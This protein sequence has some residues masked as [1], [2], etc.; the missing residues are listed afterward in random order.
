MPFRSPLITIGAEPTDLAEHVLRLEPET[1]VHL[2]TVD[3][4]PTYGSGDA[5]ERAVIANQ[6]LFGAAGRSTTIRRVVV[7]SDA[8]VYPLG[9]RSPSVFA[10]T[11]ASRTAADRFGRNLLDAERA[12]G[13]LLERRPDIA[14]TI[15]R[16]APIFGRNV[17][18]PLSRYLRLPEVPTL[19]G[20][21]P[22]WH[23]L[24]ESDAVAAVLAATDADGFGV[25]NVAPP[26]PMYLSRVIRLG[27]RKRKPMLRP[28][29]NANHRALGRRGVPVTPQLALLLEHGVVLD[30]SALRSRPDL[31]PRLTVREAVS[32]GYRDPAPDPT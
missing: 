14:V 3:R 22:R 21:D 9:P 23:L 15:L 4:S 2:L 25:V 1:I 17:D 10:E 6:A 8:A 32:A 19:A 11:D 13:A 12:A 31:T 24:H 27:R 7:K 16:L 28:F 29:L 30:T 18:N 20:F 5:H 26:T